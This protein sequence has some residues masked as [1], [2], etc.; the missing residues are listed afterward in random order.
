M[1]EIFSKHLN[2]TDIILMRLQ[3]YNLI[4]FYIFLFKLYLFLKVKN[5][6]PHSKGFKKFSLAIL[7]FYIKKLF[8]K[9]FIKD[10]IKI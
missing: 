8:I 3:I 9:N 6:F 4:Y 7:Y 5:N 2:S 1:S 10:N